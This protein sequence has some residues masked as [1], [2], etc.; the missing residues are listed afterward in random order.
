MFLEPFRESVFGKAVAR[1][2]RTLSLLAPARQERRRQTATGCDAAASRPASLLDCRV[3]SAYE[4]RGTLLPFAEYWPFTWLPWHWSSS[5]WGRSR[6]VPPQP[7]LCRS[8]S[9]GLERRVG[10]PLALCINLGF[11]PVH[12]L[13]LPARRPADGRPGF[14]PWPRPRETALEFLAGYVVEYSLSITT[15]SCSWSCSGTLPCRPPTSTG[16]SSSASWELSSRVD[17]HNTRGRSPPF[18]WVV[19]LFAAFLVFTGVKMMGG[20][21]GPVEPQRSAGDP[22]VPASASGH[23]RLHGHSFFVRHEGRSTPHRSSSRCCS[24]R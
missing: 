12:A 15:S 10:A 4:D 14:D 11:Y 17:L 5:C 16:C 24:S 2:V 6:C 8:G 13:A 18:E 7:T 9:R 19:W 3:R 21:G 20:E 22:A 23:R 1:P